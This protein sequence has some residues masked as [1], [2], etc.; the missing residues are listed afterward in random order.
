ML[1]GPVLRGK[2]YHKGWHGDNTAAVKNIRVRT[3]QAVRVYRSSI[4]HI[5]VACSKCY[6]ASTHYTP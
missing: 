6:N 3:M 2:I 5:S 4:M 1:L